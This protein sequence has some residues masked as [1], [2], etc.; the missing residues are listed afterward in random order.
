MFRPVNAVA[1]FCRFLLLRVDFREGVTAGGVSSSANI[2]LRPRGGPCTEETPA[3]RL[4]TFLVF[5]AGAP[6]LSLSYL[7]RSALVAMVALEI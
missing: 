3:F 1:A 4:R 7:N 5:R 6:D 2:A